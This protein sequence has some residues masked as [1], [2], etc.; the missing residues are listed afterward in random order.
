[1]SD[2][3]NWFGGWLGT[4][5]GFWFNIAVAF[6]AVPIYFFSPIL[7]T[8]VLSIAALILP[9]AILKRDHERDQIAEGRD[10][11]MHAKLDSLIAAIPKADNALIHSEEE[12]D[13]DR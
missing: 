11:A 9:A 10:H 1:M 8:L 4:P 5:A 13:D 3:V 12:K 6:S 2:L 7:A